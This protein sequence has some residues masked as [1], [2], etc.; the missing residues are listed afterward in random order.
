MVKKLTACL[1][2][3]IA[4]FTSYAQICTG[5]PDGGETVS[6]ILSACQNDL[7]ELS[8]TGAT[9]AEG[10][11]YQWQESKDSTSWQNL[12]GHTNDTCAITE[13]STRFYR[14]VTRC[15][16]FAGF[17]VPI[18]V[19][20]KTLL[21]CYCKPANSNCLEN[22]RISKVVFG[23]L[24]KTSSC[25][26]GGYIDYAETV[27]APDITQSTAVPVQVT[28]G[29]GGTEYVALWIDYNQN[30]TFDADEYT[31]VGFGNGVTVA[32][33]V[34][35]PDNIPTGLTKMRVRVKYNVNLNSSDA[36]VPIAVGETEDYV[37]NILSSSTCN[38]T[39]DGGSTETSMT[40]LCAVDSSILTVSG[41]TTGFSGLT[42]QWQRSKDNGSWEDMVGFTAESAVIHQDT[43]YY[44]RRMITCTGLNAYSESV[45]IA[46][47]NSN[48]C[49]CK[50]AASQ[51]NTT[52]TI[53]N[54]KFSTL[55]NSSNCS[56]LGYGDYTE[57]A[58]PIIHLGVPTKI[59]ISSNS[60]NNTLVNYF[61]VWIDYDH[62]GSFDVNEFTDLDSL[63]GTGTLDKTVNINGA[64]LTGITGMRIRSRYNVPVTAANACSALTVS[65]TED[66]LVLIEASCLSN[67]WTGLAGDNN[68]ETAGNWSCLEV[69]GANDTVII[70]TGDVF[71]NSNVT[72][73]S[74]LANPSANITVNPPFNLTVT[75]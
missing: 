10:I 23:S 7:I 9:N 4:S 35:I 64:A 42:F 60:I 16:E 49:Y 62:N 44:Y 30:G 47:K 19:T 36:C 67:T 31:S 70:D 8:V 54:V 5:L 45:Q 2:L 33:T 28:V 53:T 20:S 24:S 14:R 32:G 58:A 52:A 57:I 72:V 3:A 15:I 68:W 61:G 18:K 63:H 41:S 66:Y 38:G 69:P 21:Q 27:A 55:N 37:V 59:S 13:D 43:S 71:I 73:Y 48:I 46:I 26:P 39:P 74:L 6:S 1:A 12:A 51:C 29:P 11:T 25:S 22:D 34:Y 65:E 75:H 40:I 50:P 17:S 56:S